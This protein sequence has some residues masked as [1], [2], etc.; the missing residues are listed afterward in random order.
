MSKYVLGVDG[1]T[2]N[3]ISKRKCR[4]YLAGGWFTPSQEERLYSIKNILEDLGY[5]IFFPKEEAL[6]S[7]DSSQDWRQEVFEGNCTAI[8]NCDFMV[9][10]TDEKDMG[11]IWEAGYARGVSKPIVYFAETLSNNNFNLMLAQS[12]AA[13]ALSRDMLKTILSD[14]DIVCQVVRGDK[15]SEYSGQI[16]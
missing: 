10:I 7:P 12:G 13:V 6:C 4:V 5:D 3:I 9:C 1:L 11:T 16:E 2:E 15:V 8:K 14:T